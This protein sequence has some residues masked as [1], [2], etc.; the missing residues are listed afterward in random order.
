MNMKKTIAAV[1]ACAVAVS[2]M[3]T[4]VS[5]EEGSLHYNL[6]RNTY[7]VQKGSA[8]FKATID[9]RNALADDG[10][11]QIGFSASNDQVEVAN[12][13]YTVTGY[14][15]QNSVKGDTFSY[16]GFKEGGHTWETVGRSSQVKTNWGADGAV[17]TFTI[18]IDTK[19]IHGDE[20]F[21]ADVSVTVPHTNTANDW[22]GAVLGAK[23]QY[24]VSDAALGDLVVTDT[25]VLEPG[26]VAGTTTLKEVVADVAVVDGTYIKYDLNNNKT[27]DKY[28]DQYVS[29]IYAAP[30][31][32]GNQ[33][34]DTYTLYPVISAYTPATT[35]LDKQYPMAT[36]AN[37][38][39]MGQPFNVNTNGFEQG[40]YAQDVDGIVYIVNDDVKKNVLGSASNI[41]DYLTNFDCALANPDKG[42]AYVN[43]VPVIN[44]VIANYDEVTF[45]FNTAAQPVKNGAYSSDG[46]ADKQYTSFGQHLYNYYGDEDTGYVYTTAY[47]WNGYNLFAGA[48]VVNGQLSMSLNDTNV[49]DYGATTLSFNWDDAIS[50]ANVNTYVTY[51]SKLQL[52]TS[53]LWYWDSMD[54][55]YATGDAE[56]AASGEG[57]E[58]EDDTIGEDEDVADDDVVDDVDD[59]VV[60]DVDDDVVDDVDDDV[61]VD[62]DDTAD[63]VADVPAENPGTGNAPIALAVIPVAL[64]AAAVVAKKRG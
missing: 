29:E 49:F 33:S 56:D 11:I 28:E 26:F 8:T 17:Q 51:L 53:T 62:V 20:G 54:V 1:A 52:A 63:D 31:M 25:K 41:L 2:A 36:N 30:L 32:I 57:E 55:V 64:A 3:A 58:A 44:D 27:L 48:L 61:D 19:G 22:D 59:D 9:Y 60:D 39:T 46:D 21:V 12:A 34:L 16:V 6:V 37:T 4:T 13:V 42:L 45:T 47:D 14:N 18:P 24:V 7:K 5:A 40:V 38:F 15:I 43:V 10:Y 50:G 35:V 23:F